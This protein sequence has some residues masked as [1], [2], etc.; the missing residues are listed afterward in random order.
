MGDTIR[1]QRQIMLNAQIIREGK[2]SGPV[3]GCGECG[4]A[5]KKGAPFGL[6]DS[7]EKYKDAKEEPF[8]KD[9][10]P[11]KMNEAEVLGWNDNKDYMDKSHGTEIGDGKPFDKCPKCQTNAEAKNGTVVEGVEEPAPNQVQDWDKGL[12]KEGGTGKVE[13]KDGTPFDKKASCAGCKNVNE[14]MFEAEDDDITSLDNDDTTPATEGGT[15]PV[16]DDAPIDDTASQ[17]LGS[18][19]DNLDSD[20]EG[21]DG[22]IESLLQRILDKLDAIEAKSD[23]TAGDDSLYGDDTTSDAGPDAE[24]IEGTTDAAPADDADLGD[25]TTELGA[26]DA[27]NMHKEDET[28]YYESRNYRKLMKEDELHDFGKHP[29]YR[30]EPFTYPNPNHNEK[31]GYHDWNDDSVKGA[32]PYGEKIGDGTPFNVDP[33][34][35]ANSIAEAALRIL[36]KKI[37]ESKKK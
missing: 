15:D 29:A 5:S 25:D 31:E 30:K 13:T 32:K 23:D 24:G 19:I 33:D 9:G 6:K 8:D 3:R 18:D 16:A 22:D 10:E 27:G 4:D 12:P 21:A 28:V 35:I 17:E 7:K 2:N 26:D 11:K 34:A 14:S 36:S 1:R 37:N 20:M